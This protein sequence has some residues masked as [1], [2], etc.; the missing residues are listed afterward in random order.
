METELQLLTSH[1]IVTF[2]SSM[3]IFLTK[4]SHM[5]MPSIK[6]M[7]KVPSYLVPRRYIRNLMNSHPLHQ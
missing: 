4:T 2:V 3:L 7:K 1:L 5:A 6:R